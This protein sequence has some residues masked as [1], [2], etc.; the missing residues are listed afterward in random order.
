MLRKIII[1]DGLQIGSNPLS[2]LFESSLTLANADIKALPTTPF[3]LVSAAGNGLVI[4]PT[5]ALLLFASGSTAYT[6]INADAYMSMQYGTTAAR[7]GSMIANSSRV[8]SV[9]QLSSLLATTGGLMQKLSYPYLNDRGAADSFGL[10]GDAV[11]SDSNVN[12]DLQLMMNNNAAG[13][14]TGGSA[15]SKLLVIVTYRV[16]SV[17]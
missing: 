1:A 13:V 17:P 10:I 14:L 15:F 11:G 5:E 9:N 12:C 7:I 16:V 6:N 4:V 8:D 2:T 3:T